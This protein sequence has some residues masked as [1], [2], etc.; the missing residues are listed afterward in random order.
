MI[1]F[2]PLN[3]KIRIMNSIV[4]INNLTNPDLFILKMM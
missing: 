4:H 2:L 3:F 1:V